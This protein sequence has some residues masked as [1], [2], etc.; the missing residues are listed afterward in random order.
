MLSLA[1]AIALN[2]T[3]YSVIDALVNPKLDVQDPER[4]YWLTIWGDIIEIAST[5]RPAPRLLRTG[6]N[7]YE[8]HHAY[9]GAGGAI[10]TG[11]RRARTQLC[12]KQRRR[13]RSELLRRARR[14]TH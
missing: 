2:T 7:A 10:P 13:R 12:A 14:A 4:L 5:S 9:T 8:S 1:L 3:M 11:R 6:F